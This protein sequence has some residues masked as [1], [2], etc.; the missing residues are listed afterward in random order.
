VYTASRANAVRILANGEALSAMVSVYTVLP[1]AC[2]AARSESPNC[3]RN[4]GYRAMIPYLCMPKK[5]IRVCQKW[6][7]S[8]PKA[9]KN[10][11]RS[12][13]KVCSIHGS[14]EAGAVEEIDGEVVE[15]N[16]LRNIK[17]RHDPLQG[18]QRGVTGVL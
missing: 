2:G 6:A 7:R 12:V 16:A 3:P 8:V 15:A 18:C 13:Q 4:R 17:R 5:L 1:D 14:Q 9:F 11:T 10:C